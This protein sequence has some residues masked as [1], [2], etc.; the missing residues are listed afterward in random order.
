MRRAAKRIVWAVDGEADQTGETDWGVFGRRERAALN[1]NFA[2]E[3]PLERRDML[4]DYYER[5]LR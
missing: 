4:R 2:R 5:L 3:L 1:E